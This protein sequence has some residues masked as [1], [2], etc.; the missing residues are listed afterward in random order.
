MPKLRFT[1]SLVVPP[2]AI[3]DDQ[4]LFPIEPRHAAG[5]GLV[6]AEGAIPVNLAEIC[7]DPLDEV[8]GVGPL[9]V[10]RPLDFIPRG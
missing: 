8:H 1:R 5:H 3:P 6:V 4:H 10:T 7:E 2:F 9:G